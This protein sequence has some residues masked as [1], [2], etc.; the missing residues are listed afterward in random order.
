[1][2]S[3][4]RS[5]AKPRRF[6]AAF[7][8]LLLGGAG[9][10]ATAPVA[11]A[12]D[13]DVFTDGWQWSAVD[14]K[15]SIINDAE[16]YFENYLGTTVDLRGFTTD[17]FE[18]FFV[19][20]MF[21]TDGVVAIPLL[22]GSWT[23]AAGSW[24]NFGLS[25]F[26]A[27]AQ[28]NFGGGNILTITRTLVILGSYARW[29]WDVVNAGPAALSS[30]SLGPTGTL[31]SGTATEKV[32]GANSFVTYETA[33]FDPVI[34]HSYVANGASTVSVVDGNVTFTFDGEGAEVTIA[35]L[36]FDPCSRQDAVDAMLDLLPTLPADFGTVLDPVYADDCLFVAPPA[37]ISGATNQLLPLLENTGLDTWDYIYP[38]AIPDGMTIEV[39]SA[40]AGLSFALQNDP[41][42]GEPALRMT[43]TPQTSGEVRILVYIDNGVGTVGFPLV[44][45]FDVAVVLAATGASEIVPIALG[46]ATALL[47]LGAVLLVARRRAASRA[48]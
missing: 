7:T 2:I 33:G 31:G 22:A 38:N 42:T 27:Q 35:L 17:A 14:D 18:T 12:A 20:A 28:A 26:S 8:A 40:P 21:V 46:S 44:V 47:A 4:P 25:S 34:G 36:E 15:A 41:S 6:V 43:G 1:M 11:V 10:L 48:V 39:L 23:A 32:G 5:T 3:V 30:F 13:A 45:T 29:T 9:A 24:N 19:D 16:S 37:P